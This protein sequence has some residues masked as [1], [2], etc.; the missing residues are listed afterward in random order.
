MKGKTRLTR[1]RGRSRGKASSLPDI[2]R[3]TSGASRGILARLASRSQA[4]LIHDSVGSGAGSTVRTRGE[5][6][7]RSDRQFLPIGTADR[8]S[9][10]GEKYGHGTD[11]GSPASGPQNPHLH[12]T[13][14]FIGEKWWTWSDS[15]RR[16]HDCQS[17]ALPTAP[18]AQEK[19]LSVISC[20]LSATENPVWRL[21]AAF[22]FVAWRRGTVN[23]GIEPSGH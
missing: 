14:I 2:V 18:Q 22:L 1:G 3:G 20:Q 21:T 11:T 17:C 7:R 10:T 23:E 4:D 15:N 13:R 5:T 6:A 19:Q 16:P 9:G 12:G 8:Q